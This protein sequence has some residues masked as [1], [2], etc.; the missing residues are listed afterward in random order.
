[1]QQ[2]S[3]EPGRFLLIKP[4]VILSFRGAPHL[5][6]RVST[7][8]RVLVENLD[9]HQVE[10]AYVHQLSAYNPAEALAEEGPA[11]S[12]APE[13]ETFTKEEQERAQKIYSVL[14]PV[15]EPHGRTRQLVAQAAK[16]L[17]KSTGTVY[18]LI[19]NFDGAGLAGFIPGKRGPKGGYRLGPRVEEIIEEIINDVYLNSQKKKQVDV[20]GDIREPSSRRVGKR[21]LWP[22]ITR[23]AK[24]GSDSQRAAHSGFVRPSRDSQAES[25][26]NEASRSSDVLACSPSFER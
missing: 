10:S 25:R 1:M 23:S 4:G 15:L 6:K 20:I 11:R 18:K 7:P 13:L 16:E 5:V 21:L 14:A 19:S 8:E 12:A 22:Q 17:G 24:L 3:N 2:T 9:T 26:S